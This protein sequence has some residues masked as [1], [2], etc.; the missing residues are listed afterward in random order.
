MQNTEWNS[1]EV[2]TLYHLGYYAYTPQTETNKIDVYIQEAFKA[3]K[4]HGPT[5]LA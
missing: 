5:Q 2:L 1:S 4:S 3:T